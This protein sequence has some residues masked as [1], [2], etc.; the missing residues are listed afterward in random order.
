MRAALAGL[1]PRRG[2]L[3]L[4]ALGVLAAA[5][6]LG[7]AVTV[8]LG[9]ATGFG[10]AADRA[11]LP[12][13]VA[14]FDDEDPADV[15]RRI[16]SLANV[17]SLSLRLEV[18][19]VTLEN[20]GRF[21]RKGAVQV[22]R[23]GRRGYAVVD[24][25]DLT[26]APDEVVIE[27]G[28]AD[29]WHLGPGDTLDVGRLGRLRIA[30]VAVA[31]DN[32]AYPLASAAR[33]YVSNAGLRTRFGEEV[34]PVNLMSLWLRDDD[35]LDATLVQART[36][37]FG[38][39]DL[40]FVTR[41]GVRAL[42]DRAA[43]IVIALMV[44]LSLVTVGAAA[45]MLGAGARAEVERRLPAIGVQRVVGFPRGTI[46]RR[47]GLEAGLLALPAA[48]LG[49]ALGA[50]FSGPPTGRLLAALNEL[51]PGGTLL[52]ALLGCLVALVA[53]VAGAA[54]W[55]AW[56]AASRPPVQL[57]QGAELRGRTLRRG[58]PGGLAGL[59]ARLAL[60]RRGRALATASVLGVAGAVILLL[61]SLAGVLTQLRDDPATVGK[62]YELTAKLPAEAV[63]EVR[64]LPG[65]SAVAPRYE[66]DAVGAFALGQ[67][68][69]VIAFP[70]DH[71]RF[72]APP[73]V[74]G[75]RPRAPDEAEVG[76]GLGQAIGVRRGGT[77]AMTLPSGAEARFRVVGV[78]RALEN[79][80]RVAYVQ[81]GR[82]LRADP[83]LEPTLAIDLAPGA[84]RGAVRRQLAEGGGSPGRPAAA[85]TGN[86]G[87]LGTLASVL[88]A[89]ALVNALVCLFALSQSLALVVR[90]RRAALGVLRATGGGGPAL[91]R[92]LLGAAAAAAVP[93][94]VLA[95]ALEHLVL[96]PVVGRLAA[97]YAP[98]DLGAG[99]GPIALVAAGFVAIAAGAAAWAAAR[100]EREPVVS[101][102]GEDA[103]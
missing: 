59:G 58:I 60:M 64:A 31:P 30:G 23:S 51:P 27:R 1:A 20:A 39:D 81:P 103:G 91:R 85:T 41:D 17:E 53:L 82:L 75:R 34:R 10:R 97:D 22:V 14:R 71:G 61:L 13:V 48:A 36:A 76:L 56:R 35:R 50:L 29:T 54:A 96:G 43:G 28:L 57:L 98:L 47:A 11:D 16:A 90:E 70:G 95:V 101:A 102:L 2:R 80:G 52:A 79:E 66:A 93:A 63:P 8:G 72:E 32:V 68:F 92:V 6:M 38:V 46:A 33:V 69:R 3:A 62:R 19:N 77:L 67:P 74:E 89:V 87:F 42:L 73:L 49:L 5:T 86:S 83:V 78:T 99:A 21:V 94:L 37:S 26:G 4:A 88:R 40:R 25:R 84:D 55:P 65:V 9:L 44:A 7:T 45:V 18:N 12:D 15:R 24:G 100:F